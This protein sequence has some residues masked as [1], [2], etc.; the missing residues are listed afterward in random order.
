MSFGY[1]VLGF[2]SG[3]AGA[4]FIEATGGIVTE[5]GDFKI[6][7]FQSPGTFEVTAAPATETVDYLILAG[8]GGGSS[9]GTGSSGGGGGAG[10]LRYSFPNAPDA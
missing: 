10:G 1:Q 6:H 9:G 3:A 2:G 7:T 8:G 4:A 5:V